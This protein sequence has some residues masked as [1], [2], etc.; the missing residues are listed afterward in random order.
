[1]SLSIP[2]SPT[3]F[4]EKTKI[5]TL[6]SQK[7]PNFLDAMSHPAFGR[8]RRFSGNGNAKS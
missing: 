8:F 4:P 5:A 3:L 2:F 7:R 6:L 1:M